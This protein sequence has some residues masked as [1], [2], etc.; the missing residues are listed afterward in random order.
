MKRYKFIE[1]YPPHLKKL[2]RYAE[3]ILGS[4]DDADEVVASCITEFLEKKTYQRIEGNLSG[5]LS[6]AIRLRCHTE[7]LKQMRRESTVARLPDF[8][9]DDGQAVSIRTLVKEELLVECP[10]CFKANLNEYG[11]CAMCGTI[12]PSHYRTQS[13]VIR[14]DEESLS[15][16]IDFNK[17]IDVA[18]ALARL[19]PKEQMI[20]KA[21]I[22][23]NE[24][25]ETVSVLTGYDRMNLWRTWVT[26]KRKL[27]G[28]LSEYA[29]RTLGKRGPEALKRAVNLAIEST[30]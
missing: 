21:T 27:Q 28:Y 4:Y 5:F 8:D 2:R 16:D 17:Q 3:K 15:M 13:N 11:A 20:I 24:T 23:G 1:Q 25:F 30:R 18:K 19:E 14:M 29:P 26:A 6:K 10:F 22:L 9:Y 7:K 12:V